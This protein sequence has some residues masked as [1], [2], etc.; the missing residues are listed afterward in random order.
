MGMVSNI[1]SAVEP[2]RKHINDGAVLTDRTISEVPVIFLEGE[3]MSLSEA[4]LKVCQFMATQNP[5]ALDKY[6][7]LTTDEVVGIDVLV[8]DLE[9]EADWDFANSTR[10][11]KLCG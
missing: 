11:P 3:P 6:L 8:G 9:G 5:S 1:E 10:G 2:G 4:R 7:V